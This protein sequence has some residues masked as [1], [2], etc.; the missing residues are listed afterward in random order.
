MFTGPY[1]ELYIAA[2]CAV[3]FFFFLAWYLRIKGRKELMKEAQKKQIQEQA[4]SSVQKPASFTTDTS[5]ISRQPEM[6][7]LQLQA[8]ERLIILCERLGF[9]SL[10]SRLP[11]KTSSA[12]ELRQLLVQTIQGEFDYNLS[13]Q[14]Y[15]SPQAWDAIKNLKEQQIFIIHQLAET[16]SSNATGNELAAA[17]HELLQHDENAT[18]QPIV[19]ALLNKEARLLIQI[20]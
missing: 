14:L 18:L 15:V 4:S 17:I 19:A 3:V 12:Q 6:R 1:A 9:Q 8:Y 10:I 2:I 7:K 13:Q 5:F 11:V 16:L 20:G